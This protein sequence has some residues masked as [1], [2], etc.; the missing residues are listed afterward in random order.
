V[1]K[2]SKAAVAIE[3]ETVRMGVRVAA[4]TIENHLKRIPDALDGHRN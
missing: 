4:R 2:P 1:K 3:G